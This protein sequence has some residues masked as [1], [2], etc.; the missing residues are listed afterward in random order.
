MDAAQFLAEALTPVAHLRRGQALINALRATRPELA[1]GLLVADLDPYYND[2]KLWPAVA[3]I[4]AH[5]DAQ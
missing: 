4:T 2:A 3:W 1:H 5:W